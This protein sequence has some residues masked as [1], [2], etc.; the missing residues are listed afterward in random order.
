[1]Q[2]SREIYLVKILMPPRWDN[3][4]IIQVIVAS[5]AAFFS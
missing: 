1:M 2:K 5:F 3:Y 4:V